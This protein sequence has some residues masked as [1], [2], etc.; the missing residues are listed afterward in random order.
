[1]IGL[2]RI[3]IKSKAF[4]DLKVKDVNF[5]LADSHQPNNRVLC[6]VKIGV[7]SKRCLKK[8]HG[9]DTDNLKL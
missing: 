4:V 7:I 6:P 5:V 1:M 3:G 2:R 9:G 8:R